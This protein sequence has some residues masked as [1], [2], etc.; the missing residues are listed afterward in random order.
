MDEPERNLAAQR[1]PSR[2]R[3]GALTWC[4]YAADGREVPETRFCPTRRVP[5]PRRVLVFAARVGGPYHH[6]ACPGSLAF[7]DPEKHKSTRPQFG[8]RAP[9]NR[10]DLC[11]SVIHLAR[12][13]CQPRQSRSLAYNY[14]RRAHNWF[15]QKRANSRFERSEGGIVC[16]SSVQIGADTLPPYV[17]RQ[18]SLAHH[19]GEL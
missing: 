1:W 7:G 17:F 5:H 14:P 12:N 11:L 15:M 3:Q 19:L 13:H 18:N 2:S 9:P 16:N 10:R 6:S 8:T 4:V